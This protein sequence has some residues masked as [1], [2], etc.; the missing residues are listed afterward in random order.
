MKTDV[1]VA[2]MAR[3]PVAGEAKKRLAPRLGAIGAAELH[4]MLVRHALTVISEAGMP[5]AL[6]CAPDARHPFFIECAREYP[7][8]LHDQIG[9][10]LGRRMAHVFEITAAPT[11]LMGSD[12]P[13]IDAALLRRCAD[14][15]RAGAPAIFLPA[16]DGGYALVGLREPVADI[17]VDIP[18]GSDCVMMR[19]RERLAAKGIAT[20]EPAIVWDV[21]RPE[22]VDR[23]AALGFPIP[24]RTG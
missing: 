8:E 23:L 7:I 22:D 5:A 14:E 4:A 13:A 20:Q 9:D 16:E 10:D 15:L 12:C 17:F 21:D 24:A 6:W 19:T 2:L 3:A 18:W 11:L 1:H